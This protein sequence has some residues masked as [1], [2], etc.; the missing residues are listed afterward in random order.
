MA[1][2]RNPRDLTDRELLALIEDEWL[3]S[4][5]DAGPS[6]A[7]WQSDRLTAVRAEI[8]RRRP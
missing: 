8:E 2:E 5:D 3:W 6:D 4:L 7:G 1:T